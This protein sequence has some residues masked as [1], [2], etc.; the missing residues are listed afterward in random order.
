[1]TEAN[2]CQARINSISPRLPKIF[3]APQG[4]L[5]P[6]L[7]LM[8]KSQGWKIVHWSFDSLDCLQKSLDQQLEVFRNKAIR[9]G[10]ILLF[11]DDQQI[12]IDILEALLPE[13]QR[14]GF[15]FP[16]IAELIS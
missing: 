2:D 7:F 15:M 13:W 3:R 1:M 5:S 6:A 14:Q 11:H 4:Q 12:T 8:L 10:D 16:T 9:N